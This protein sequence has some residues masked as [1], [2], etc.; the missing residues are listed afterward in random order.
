[1]NFAYTPTQQALHAQA[2]E[3]GRTVL[4]PNTAARVAARSFGSEAWG[5]LAEA[6]YTGMILPEAFGGAALS[7]ADAAV[8]LEALATACSDT[9]LL[10]SLGAHLCAGVVPVW[11]HG[12]AEQHTLL[13]EVSKGRCII[14]NAITEAHSGSNA[15]ALRSTA[16]PN[17]QGYTITGHKVFCTNATLAHHFVVYAL[18]DV[19]K[20]FFGGIS[21]FLLPREAVH[22]GPALQ[23]DA[24][25]TSPAAEVM[26]NGVQAH[27]AQLLGKPGAG[28]Q[29]FLHSMNWERTLLS[30]LHCGS[31]QLLLNRCMA[32]VKAR[33]TGSH[34]LA[35]H[36]SVQFKLA[37]MAVD[38]ETSRV[39]VHKAAAFI[40]TGKNATAA[41]ARAK[42]HTS[43]AFVRVA[44][45]A[46][47][48]H[49][50]N[51][52][53]SAYALTQ[54]MAD[55]QA[56]CIYSGPNEVLRSVLAAQG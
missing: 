22:V 52:I 43:E 12:S 13:H 21:A 20:G 23:K 50:G 54:F 24:L 36:Q 14:A 5:Q 26:L 30:A 1:M 40:D 56:A 8:V 34:T 37:E 35:Q 42:V 29:I 41:A 55:A 16:T 25:H 39:L 15:F 53:T 10:F 17:E 27:T 33:S 4:E 7:A 51:G 38:I 2:L 28:V 3:F 11:M 31:M 48:L 9:G 47:Q 18:T 44:S 32:Y 6:G 19:Q 45:A 46:V 49:G